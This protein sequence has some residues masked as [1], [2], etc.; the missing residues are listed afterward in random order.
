M[1]TN[2]DLT[3][4]LHIICFCLGSSSGILNVTLLGISSQQHS[5]ELP[6]VEAAVNNINTL[7]NS[8]L[9]IELRLFVPSY[10]YS[11][12]LFAD[13]IV[14]EVADFYYSFTNKN[15]PDPLLFVIGASKYCRR[16]TIKAWISSP[17]RQ[18]VHRQFRKLNCT[19]TSELS[20]SA[21]FT[22]LL[23]PNQSM[24]KSKCARKGTSFRIKQ[25]LPHIADSLKVWEI[26]HFL[27]DFD[28][29]GFHRTPNGPRWIWRQYRCD[30]RDFPCKSIKFSQVRDFVN[31]F[32]FKPKGQC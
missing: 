25:C 16:P 4:V 14:H 13:D 15:Q 31:E 19:E 21:N 7:Y 22:I 11:C 9:H 30:V 3:L 27:T 10:V 26:C 29:T 23:Q 5:I 1:R 8:T 20:L 28:F 17:T 12:E 6:A 18:M 32:T 24:D 2:L